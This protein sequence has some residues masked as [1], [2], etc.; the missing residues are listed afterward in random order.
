MPQFDTP[1]NT[2]EQSLDRVL[3]NPLP[4]LLVLDSDGGLQNTLNEV[5]RADAGKLLVV[6]LNTRENPQAGKKLKA[7]GSPAVIVWKNGA[8]QSRL[9]APEPEQV[10]QA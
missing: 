9:V 1:I 7:Q 8:E 2:N 3:A 10:R 5:A 6:K 4:V